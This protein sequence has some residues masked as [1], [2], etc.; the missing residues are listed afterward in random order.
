MKLSLVSEITNKKYLQTEEKKNFFDFKLRQRVNMLVFVTR[1]VHQEQLKS[2]CGG[3][4]LGDFSAKPTTQRDE[5]IK[6]RMNS[7]NLK[8]ANQRSQHHDNAALLQRM[9]IRE[10]QKFSDTPHYDSEF[11]LKNSH[12]NSPVYYDPLHLQNFSSFEKLSGTGQQLSESGSR[13]EKSFSKNSKYPKKENYVTQNMSP[14]IPVQSRFI[15]PQTPVFVSID[16]DPV[17]PFFASDPSRVSAFTP[18]KPTHPHSSNSIAEN[19]LLPHQFTPSK[20]PNVF[21]C[22]GS[23]PS[24]SHVKPRN[25]NSNNH[26]TTSK[27][28]ASK[29]V[30][31][32]RDIRSDSTK[33]PKMS[34]LS[35]VLKADSNKQ[36]FQNESSY[37]SPLSK[38]ATSNN[39]TVTLPTLNNY[40][41]NKQ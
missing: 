4:R 2:H 30:V 39:D 34:S 24:H 10:N 8:L 13:E 15:P 14:L 25:T 22:V 28:E 33:L 40:A 27:L 23:I 21:E 16:H 11:S 18:V 19:K 6:Q 32:P 12:P 37:Y 36:T 20:G 7:Q 41:L 5:G 3:Q 31:D 29:P 1:S 17:V 9:N 26:Y 38:N 35:E